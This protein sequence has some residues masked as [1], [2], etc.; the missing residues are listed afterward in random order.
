MALVLIP[1]VASYSTGSC[2]AQWRRELPVAVDTANG[3]SGV[4]RGGDGSLNLSCK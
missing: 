3:R 4:G 1:A 2:E